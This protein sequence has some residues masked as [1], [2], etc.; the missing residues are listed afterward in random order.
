MRATVTVQL[1]TLTKLVKLKNE[2]QLL[3]SEQ[4]TKEFILIW[5]EI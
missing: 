2:N 4:F 1:L 5:S 3:N